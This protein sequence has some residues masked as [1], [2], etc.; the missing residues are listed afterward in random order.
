MATLARGPH[1]AGRYEVPWDGRGP[2]GSRL[3]SGVYV[4]RLQSGERSDSR[5]LL[6]LR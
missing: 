3:A 4:Y 2:G 5:R 6:L 1:P